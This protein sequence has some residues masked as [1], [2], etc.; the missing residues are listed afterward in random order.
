LYLSPMKRKENEGTHFWAYRTNGA[1]GPAKSRAKEIPPKPKVLT[2]EALRKWYAEREKVEKM[3]EFLRRWEWV[4]WA[5]TPWVA[6]ELFGG[7]PMRSLI[8]LDADALHTLLTSYWV[9]IRIRKSLLKAWLDRELA[10]HSD[11]TL[12]P[13]RPLG[14]LVLLNGLK[15]GRAAGI[16]GVWWRYEGSVFVATREGITQFSFPDWPKDILALAPAFEEPHPAGT[17]LKP[18]WESYGGNTLYLWEGAAKHLSIRPEISLAMILPA[19]LGQASIQLIIDVVGWE[20]TWLPDKLLTA[21]NALWVGRNSPLL[22]R[23]RGWNWMDFWLDYAELELERAKWDTL[24]IETPDPAYLP[25]D[26]LGRCFVFSAP[27][28][29]IVTR[30]EVREYQEFCDGW[31]KAALGGA[32]KLALDAAEL[33]P[34]PD[35]FMADIPFREWLSWAY[36]YAQ[37]LGVPT[38]EF[39]REVRRA[40]AA[41]YKLE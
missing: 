36:R 18:D 32:I 14:E 38:D 20:A 22:L 30:D 40:K 17:E 27:A 12:P 4:E 13:L 24:F 6:V 3:A 21:L 25:A 34:P 28:R 19:I 16:T 33:P 9:N 23:R 29:R 1:K 37:V 31:Q 11:G 10:L 15:Y 5:H 2:P 39:E 41:A 26:F 8:P 7:Y 35:D